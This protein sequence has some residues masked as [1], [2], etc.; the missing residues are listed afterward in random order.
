MKPP[1]ANTIC[2]LLTLMSL[3][4]A[5][6]VPVVSLVTGDAPSMPIR[7]GLDK[8]RLALQQQGVRVEEAAS[9]PAAIGEIVAV[10]G[11]G[12]GSGD[13]AQLISELHLTPDPEPE[14][15]VIRMIAFP[16]SPNH[17][18]TTRPRDEPRHP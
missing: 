1:L 3:P 18:P 11:L 12:S 13:A 2:L 5:A 4:F 15:L 16:P 8:L 10:A 9:L 7:H 14:S 17:E 6:A